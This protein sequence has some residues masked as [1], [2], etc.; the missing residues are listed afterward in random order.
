MAHITSSILGEHFIVQPAWGA[1]AA[2]GAFLLVAAYL[3]ALL[4]RLSAGMG[5]GVTARPVRR[6]WLG[7]R[8]R[9]AGRRIALAEAD[10]PG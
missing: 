4:P 3:I 1:W 6:C 7:T 5:A 2:L 8:I 10:V 9:A